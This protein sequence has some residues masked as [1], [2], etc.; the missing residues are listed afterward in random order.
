MKRSDLP[1]LDDLRAFEATARKGSV[2]A[3]AN[4]LAL[5]HAAV[6]RRLSR[7][8]EAIGVQLF[9]K[10]GRGLV[11]TPAGESLRDACRRSFDD[12]LRTITL[13]RNSENN[14]DRAVVLSCERSVAM[15]WLI[16]RLSR[17]EDTHPDVTV[18]LSVGGGPIDGQGGGAFLALRRLDFALDDRWVVQPLF[19][20]RVGPVMIKD[21]RASF[22]IGDYVALVTKTRPEAWDQWL[23][24]HAD[25]P[26]PRERRAMD[27]HF[28]MVEAACAGLGVGLS[29]LVV[30]TDDV[31]GNRLVAPFGFSSDGSGYG[32]VHR[33]GVAL[34]TDAQLLADW[35]RSEGKALVS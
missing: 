30:A 22:E 9:R 2:R 7:L 32:L 23:A 8:S 33:A 20:E 35:I 31:D 3:A 25:A 1:Y 6:S 17:F 15:R 14:R 27:H 5:T 29:P 19:P 12:L 13:I 26:R 10:A 21:M 24:S 4:E 34:S 28:L 11:L 18:H 16:P